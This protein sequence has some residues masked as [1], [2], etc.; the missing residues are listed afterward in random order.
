MEHQECTDVAA[1][2]QNPQESRRE[3]YLVPV[4]FSLPVF[5]GT[6]SSVA[7]NHITP[8]AYKLHK[9]HHMK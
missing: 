1:L 6:T 5:V 8:S 2:S 4:A 3:Q 9:C 7:I